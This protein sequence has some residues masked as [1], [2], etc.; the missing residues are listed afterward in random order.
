MAVTTAYSPFRMQTHRLAWLFVL[1]MFVVVVLMWFLG[2]DANHMLAEVGLG[3]FCAATL[4]S[5]LC[6]RFAPFL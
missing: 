2:H 5:I 4:F 1:S 3:L 6:R